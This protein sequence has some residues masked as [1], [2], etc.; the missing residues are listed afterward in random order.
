[1]VKEQTSTISLKQLLSQLAK[2]DLFWFL[3]NHHHINELLLT[4]LLFSGPPASSGKNL[5][6]SGLSSNTRATDLKVCH[7]LVFWM[8]FALLFHPLFCISG[9]IFEV[10]SGFGSKDRHVS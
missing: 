3:D 2:V 1:M 8:L 9:S 7:C 6:I 4:D 5:W 10:W